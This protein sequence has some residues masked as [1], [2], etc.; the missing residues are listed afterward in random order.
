M[1]QRL[2]DGY[3]EVLTVHHRLI[4][5]SLEAHSGREVANQGDGF[6]AVFPSAYA[7]VAAAEEVQRNLASRS[8]PLDERVRVRIGV[9]TGEAIET[10]AGLV[11]VDVN[12]AARIGAIA[13]G[14]QVIISSTTAALVANSMPEGARLRDLGLHRLKDLG[15]AEHL[16]QL[17]LDGLPGDF[18]PLR[19]LA[20]PILRHNLP[21]QVSSFIGRETQLAELRR[22]VSASRLVTLTGPGGTGKTRLALQLGAELLDGEGDGVWLVELAPVAQEE[23]VPNQ[24]ASVLR[25]DEESGRPMSETLVEILRSKNLLIILDNCEHVVGAAAK[26]VERILRDC[27]HTH[28]VTTSREP[29]CIGG[30]TIYQ[31]PPLSVPQATSA[32]TAEVIRSEAALLLAER[33]LAHRRDFAIDEANAATVASICR[34]LD[35]VPLAIELAAARLQSM[36]LAD[37]DRRLHDRFRLLTGGPRTASARQQTLKA[38]VD[39]SYDLLV[40]PERRVLCRLSVFADGCDAAAG[41]AVCSGPDVEDWQVLDILGSLVQKSLLQADVSAP[42]TRYRLLETVRQYAGERLSETG[43]AAVAETKGAHARVFLDVVEEAYRHEGSP[44]Q[45]VWLNRLE[46]EHDNLRHAFAF[47]LA[48]GPAADAARF[49]VR[50]GWFWLMRTHF[51]EGITALEAVLSPQQRFP[52]GRESACPARARQVALPARRPSS[53]KVDVGGGS[54]PRR[55]AGGRGAGGVTALQLGGCDVP[56]AETR[57]RACR[58]SC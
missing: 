12:R 27:P 11:G 4:R 13:H 14:G 42:V 22:A 55:R 15:P 38:M 57:T 32:T 37:L 36:S 17:D 7:A 53:S 20:N 29:L 19:S 5:S 52:G 6:F 56:R 47:V 1:L 26:V 58:P 9:H 30:E 48:A 3:T 54:R 18:P 24:L 51:A 2:G 49:A 33:S 8:W 43:A 35:G 39:W 16:F 34:R 28:F 21:E 40:K 31:V 50:L 10:A 44:D 41:E 46:L 25:A 45:I 23:L